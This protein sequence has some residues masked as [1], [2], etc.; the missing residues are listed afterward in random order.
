MTSQQIPIQQSGVSTLPGQ[1]SVMS[2]AQANQPGTSADPAILPNM[3]PAASMN[4]GG[5]QS[6]PQ[7]T[8]SQQQMLSSRTDK[9][10]QMEKLLLVLERSTPEQQQQLFQKMP[11]LTPDMQQSLLQRV[12]AIRL[13]KQQQLHHQQ[14]QQQQQPQLHTMSQGSMMPGQLSDVMGQPGLSG[15]IGQQSHQQQQQSQLSRQAQQQGAMGVQMGMQRAQMQGQ[16]Q[17]QQQSGI[18]STFPW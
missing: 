5:I 18:D 13:Q 9:A 15:G 2:V 3:N 11:Q 6:Q 8:Q 4:I 16:Q 12:Q 7:H 10:A 17:Q 14:Q 1:Q